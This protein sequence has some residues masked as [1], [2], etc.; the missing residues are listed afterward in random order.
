LRRLAFQSF[1]ASVLGGAAAYATLWFVG[2]VVDIDTVVGIVTQGFCGGVV[3][4]VVAVAVLKL[5]DNFELAE[6]IEALRRRFV[7]S[8]RVALEPSDVS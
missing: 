3:G 2:S 1:E 8:P 6:T 7:D 4:I 5:L